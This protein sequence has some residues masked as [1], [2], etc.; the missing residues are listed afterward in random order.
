MLGELN[1]DQI[2][3]LLYGQVIGRI[4]CSANGIT[5]VV[6]VTYAYDGKHIYAHSKD[7]MKIQM[8]RMNPMVCFEVDQMEDMANWQSVIV[9]GRFE[10]LKN[11]EQ[12]FGLHKLTSRLQPLVI[13]ETSMPSHEIPESHQNDAGPYKTVVFR[14]E[15]KEKT[16]RFEKR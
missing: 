3:K 7:G 1:P 14:I 5:Y 12:K 8:M 10:E 9:W 4:G 13:S 6:P 15:V 2:E 16:G 11:S